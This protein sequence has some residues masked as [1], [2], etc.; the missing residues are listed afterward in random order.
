MTRVTI[1]HNPQCSKSRK[2][3]TLLKNNNIEPEIIEYLKNNL[4][5][6]AIMAI[7]LKLGVSVRDI[8]RT[9]EAEYETQRLNE[10][11]DYS[12]AAA[13]AKNPILMQRP[14]VVRGDNARIGRPPEIVLELLD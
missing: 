12:L 7:A 11:S 1:Y 9:N 8:I 6:D 13:I 3:L 10:V 5:A 2:T 14:I 4:D